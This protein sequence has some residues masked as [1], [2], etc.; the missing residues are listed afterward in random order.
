[1]S[2]T[3]ST[4]GKRDH[5]YGKI[6]R[7]NYDVNS[8]HYFSPHLYP[9]K[10]NNSSHLDLSRLKSIHGLESPFIYTSV[11]SLNSA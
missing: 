6:I 11:T 2:H 7:L 3:M 8:S 9:W 4:E 5:K 1:M 10:M